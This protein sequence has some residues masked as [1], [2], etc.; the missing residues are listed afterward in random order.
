MKYLALTITIILVI[1]TAGCI[2]QTN[3]LL[4]IE[5]CERVFAVSEVPLEYQKG[6]CFIL[7]DKK[8]R[9]I[10]TENE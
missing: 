5:R 1:V 4:K 6:D 3:S 8:S 10:K 9:V 2:H 7:T